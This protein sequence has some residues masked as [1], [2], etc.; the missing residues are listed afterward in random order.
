MIYIRYLFYSNTHLITKNTY[1]L[2]FSL[3]SNELFTSLDKIISPRIN[4]LETFDEKRKY[5]QTQCYST[6]KKK[7]PRCK[8]LLCVKTFSFRR[9]NVDIFLIFFPVTKFITGSNSR[10]DSICAAHV[11]N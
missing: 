4:Q 7:N 8:E 11:Y 2:F 6:K 3:G 10:R 9:K 1:I 5:F